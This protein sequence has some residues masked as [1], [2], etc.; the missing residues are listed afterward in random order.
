MTH[1]RVLGGD[2]A[3]KDC[4]TDV[5]SIALF[6]PGSGSAFPDV[7]IPRSDVVAAQL[8]TP[9]GW[10]PAAT[11]A[12]GAAIGYTIA[13]EGG[14]IVGTVFAGLP[15]DVTFLVTLRDGRRFVAGGSPDLFQ[16]FVNDAKRS[17]RR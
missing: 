16:Q 4:F 6:G 13:G 8:A 11:T 9:R 17:R 7:R 10:S 3:A 15:R 5:G 14:L 12:A 1:F 2:F